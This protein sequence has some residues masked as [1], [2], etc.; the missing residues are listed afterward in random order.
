MEESAVIF[1]MSDLYKQ[2]LIKNLNTD[3]VSLDWNMGF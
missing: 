2:I 3:F 1:T